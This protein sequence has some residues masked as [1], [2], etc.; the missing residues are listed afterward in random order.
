M[1]DMDARTR[2]RAH[3]RVGA[4]VPLYYNAPGLFYLNPR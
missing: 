4:G 3:A 2:G 1:N